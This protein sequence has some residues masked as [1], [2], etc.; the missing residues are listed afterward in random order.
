MTHLVSLQQPAVTE[1][2][3]SLKGE[4]LDA[5]DAGYH[6]ARTVWNAMIDRHPRLIA[7]CLD[8]DDVVQAVNFARTQNLVVSVRGG[9]HN[10]AGKAVCDDG[11]MVDLSLM[12]GIAVD[13]STRTARVEA[14]V[15]WAELDQATQAHGLATTGGTVSHT[16]VA[17]L[18]L[19][20]GLGWLLAQHG[21]ASDNL[22]AAE[23]VLADGRQVRVSDDEYPD[24]FWAI[25]GGG[26]NFGIVTAFEFRLHAVG[27]TVLGGMVLYPADQARDVLRFYR[28]FSAGC[29]DN[30][31]VYAGLLT[32]PDGTRVVAMIPTWFGEREA[33]EL[34]L[35]PLR[36][37]GTP[38]ADMVGPLLYTQLQTMFDAAAPHGLPRYWKS[39]YFAE[40]P[41]DLIEQIVA[42]VAARTSPYSVVLLF[43]MHGTASRIAPD[44]T[45]FPARRDQWDFD[46]IAQWSDPKSA[47]EH[48]GWAREFWQAVTP[49]STGV[50]VNHLD[51]DDP[52]ARVRTAYGANYERLA[53]IKAAY[54]P[55]N[56]FRLNH[57]IEPHTPSR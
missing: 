45:A 32:L 19:G 48:I 25:R 23:M 34:A 16:G 3:T 26:G 18:T 33:G 39:G 15:L 52:A 43:H 46:V 36:S 37:F 42:H 22:L 57:N 4:L 38:I 8:A 13:P 53:R 49:W 7:R 56:F 21:L 20:G 55:T 31:T 41:D 9:G 28:E 17:G 6:A 54:D 1:L 44:A 40:L 51:A 47:D 14:G 27:P 50:Y 2:R 30:L 35:A 29:P 10:V 11:L 12:K 24:L 5:D